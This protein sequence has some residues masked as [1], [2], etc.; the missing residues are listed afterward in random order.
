MQF[1]RPLIALETPRGGGVPAWIA[2]VT[3]DKKWFVISVSRA[4]LRTN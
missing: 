2:K 1:G 4:A 3:T